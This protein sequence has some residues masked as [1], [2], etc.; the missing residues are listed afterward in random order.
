MNCTFLIVGVSLICACVAQSSTPLAC[1]LKAFT[2]QERAEWRKLLDQVMSAVTAAHDLPDGYSFAIDTGK[3]SFTKT[4][5]WVDLERKCC[6]FFVFELSMRG[7]SG[8]VRLSLRGREGVKAF[9]AADFH[10]LFEHLKASSP[11]GRDR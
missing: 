8:D 1:N 5:R 7:E 9:I 3:A 10:S 2:G 4:A 6:P 11:G